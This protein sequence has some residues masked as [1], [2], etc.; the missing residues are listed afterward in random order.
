VL[1]GPQIGEAYHK[2]RL[3]V[4]IEDA[5]KLPQDQIHEFQAKSVS[6]FWHLAKREA[7]NEASDPLCDVSAL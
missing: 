6:S 1:Y 3:R 2:I 4:V 5:R 7:E